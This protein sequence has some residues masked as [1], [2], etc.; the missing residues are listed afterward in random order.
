ML[1]FRRAK[2]ITT[3]LNLAPLVDVIL[4]L[5]IFFMLSS[6]FIQPNIKLN[7]PEG[8]NRE[9]DRQ[10]DIVVTVDR[11]GRIF[12]NLDE[13]SLEAF[14]PA[15]AGRLTET[16]QEAITFRGDREIVYDLVIKVVD[17]AKRAGA[18]TINFAHGV[19]LE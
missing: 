18:K 16:G 12:I 14:G 17:R 1:R 19:E 15:L 6:S 10:Q 3:G 5:L 7:L 11:T 9:T 4:L 13:V 8:R 2:R